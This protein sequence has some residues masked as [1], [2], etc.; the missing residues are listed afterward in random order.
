MEIYSHPDIPEILS[1]PGNSNCCDCNA[2]KPKWASLNNGV[3]LCLKC[4]GIHRS[5]GSEITL[6]RSLQ[7][8][9]WTDNQIL[10]L[11]KGGNNK[12][13]QNL[14]EYNIPPNLQIDLKYKS[15]AA[16]YYRKL[17]K[18]E[19]E[20]ISNKK[21]YKETEI[22]K[23]KL[24]EGKEIIELKKDQKVNNLNLNENVNEEKKEEGFLGVFGSFLNNVKKTAG[25]V[26]GKITKEIDELKIGEKIKGAGDTVVDYAIAGGNFIKNK[27]E[28][29]INSDFVQGITKTAESGFN[30]VVEKT[31]LLLNKDNNQQQNINPNLLENNESE[32]KKN[33][34]VEMSDIIDNNNNN[35]NNL[36]DINNINNIN[37]LDN[38]N[39]NNNDNAIPNKENKNEDIQKKEEIASEEKQKE[40]NKSDKVDEKQKEDNKL[41]KIEEKQKEENKIEI[42]ANDNSN[43]AIDNKIV[44]EESVEHVQEKPE[45]P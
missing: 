40:E 30:T 41:D 4:A 31:K 44:K 2:E 29:A 17:L 7:I 19:V 14:S 24:E 8:D 11:S 39:N 43:N 42:G 12:F 28:Q 27:S 38:V 23:P 45:N 3:F 13:K 36:N 34:D 26:A 37:K 6:I 21:Y 35:V 22:I 9:S 20:K 18:N 1:L 25:D 33:E 5:L 10:Y 32:A 15:K 16:D